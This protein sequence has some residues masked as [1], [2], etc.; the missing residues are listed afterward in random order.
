MVCHSRSLVVDHLSEKF[1][2][3][4]VGIAYLYCDYKAAEDS[5]SAVNLFSSLTRQLAEQLPALASELKDFHRN[6]KNKS[7]PT[8][9]E[10]CAVLL[11]LAKKFTTTFLLV[12][13]LDECYQ[14]HDRG[15]PAL[16]EVLSGLDKAKPFAKIFVTSRFQEDIRRTFNDSPRLDILAH[17]R[18]ME[19]YIK[20]RIEENPLLLEFTTD[21]KD[22]MRY[23]IDTVCEKAGRMCEPNTLIM[24]LSISNFWINL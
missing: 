10:V 6:H 12:D 21:E 19:R 11:L 13:A 17:N 23:I 4:N 3:E 1:C 22:L 9:S 24:L 7:R 18:D 16:Q 15:R 14:K 20:S 2:Q 8:F 5:Q